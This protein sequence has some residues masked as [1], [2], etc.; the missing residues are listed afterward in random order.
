[1]YIQSWNQCSCSYR[2]IGADTG[3]APERSWYAGSVVSKSLWDVNAV[4][5]IFLDPAVA[6]VLIEPV[7]PA[8]YW[9][10]IW[11]LKLTVQFAAHVAVSA[12]LI[13]KEINPI[14]IVLFYPLKLGS[15]QQEIVASS[16][17]FREGLIMSL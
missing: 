6:V 2:T 17:P 15:R 16:Q 1:M 8:R 14:R 12:V 9:P 10:D 4:L 11:V 7:N 3:N 13:D 5:D